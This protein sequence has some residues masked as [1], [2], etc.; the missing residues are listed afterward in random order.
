MNVWRT[1]KTKYASTAFTGIGAT[2][3]GGRFNSIGSPPVVYTACDTLALALLEVLVHLH[4]RIVPPDFSYI[5]ATIPDDVS[6]EFLRADQLPINWL[7]WPHPDSTR[8][9]GD[10]WLARQSSCILL[11][12]SAVTRV[13]YN[14]LINPQHPD[15]GLIEVEP[16]VPLEFDQ[17][18]L[19]SSA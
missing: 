4:N 15:F 10:D 19:D 11:V 7:M 14:C 9:I 6:R 12:P 3:V 1:S 18:L 17:R 5:T 2:K 8:V 13:D 16:P